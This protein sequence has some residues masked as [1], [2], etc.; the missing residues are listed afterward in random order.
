[1]F[2]TLGEFW[3]ML[4]NI[5]IILDK[6]WGQCQYT[7]CSSKWNPAPASQG[8]ITPIQIALQ[9]CHFNLKSSKYAYLISIITGVLI[10][11]FYFNSSLSLYFLC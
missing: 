10:L 3:A 5:P 7:C 11:V 8:D 6:F 9:L 1:M 4:Y 2:V